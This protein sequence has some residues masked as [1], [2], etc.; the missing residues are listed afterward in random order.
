M[1]RI[2]ALGLALALLFSL[3]ACQTAPQSPGSSESGNAQSSAPAEASAEGSAGAEVDPADQS[4]PQAE[5]SASAAPPPIEE[6]E[7]DV[8][9]GPRTFGLSMPKHPTLTQG[10]VAKALAK[11][12][13]AMGDTLIVAEAA[14]D[15]PAQIAQLN[16]LAP[17]VSAIFLCPVDEAALEETVT[18]LSETVPV[19]G[20]GDWSYTPDG[21]VSLVHSDDYNAGYVC[22]IDLAERCPDGGEVLVLERPD[23]TAMTERVTGFLE[24]TEESGVELEIADEL[25]VQEDS[26]DTEKLVKKALEENP[27]VVGFFAAS[28]RDAELLLKAVK[29]TQCLVYSA[30]GSPDLKAELG[31]N[32]N[33][34]AL[35]AQ[36]P[37]ALAKVLE[38]SANQYLD[39]EAVE[40]DQTVGTFLIT[41]ENVEK[42]GVEGWQ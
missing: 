28:D 30:D 36:S 9:R 27:Q 31:K 40:E 11:R 13:E 42:Y 26:K 10:A 16:A 7:A 3:S 25:E 2:L 18:A 19:F 1:K 6:P 4:Q 39:G 24:A 41:A 5:A 32:A 21:M 22:G 14:A 33:L 37:K 17:Q 15:A 34:A 29:G 38:E 8:Q 20:F 23:S 12:M 35:G